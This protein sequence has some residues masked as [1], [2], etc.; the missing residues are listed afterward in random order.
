M[1]LVS[2][3]YDGARK[4]APNIR[5]C[6]FLEAITASL[7]NSWVLSRV[8]NRRAA[9]NSAYTP[10]YKSR[11]RSSSSAA[12]VELTVD[13]AVT[14]YCSSLLHLVTGIKDNAEIFPVVLD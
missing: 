3:K 6:S 1:E 4:R 11:S 13:D 12:E 9:T 7:K 5:K 14:W 2:K 8:K 10:R